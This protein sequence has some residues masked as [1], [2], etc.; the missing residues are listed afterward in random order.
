MTLW[1]VGAKLAD[2]TNTLLIGGAA[3]I[4]LFLLTRQGGGGGNGAPLPTHDPWF[5]PPGGGGGGGGITSLDFTGLADKFKTWA[6]NTGT[7]DTVKRWT[8]SRRTELGI[9]GDLFNLD[10]GG[11]GGAGKPAASIADVLSALNTAT[12]V[13]EVTARF[14]K[15]PGAMLNMGL[16]KQVLG[17]TVEDRLNQ[18]SKTVM[19]KGLADTLYRV[20][21]SKHTKSLTVPKAWSRYINKPA[22]SPMGGFGPQSYKVSRGMGANALR[23]VSKGAMLGVPGLGT[24]V[25]LGR[26]ALKAVS[27]T[28]MLPRVGPLFWLAEVPATLYE[29]KTGKD[30]PVLG[31]GGTSL[32][33]AAASHGKDIWRVLRATPPLAYSAFMR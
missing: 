4:G 18:V 8:D 1:H 30:I 11:G 26:G 12:D 6:L 21:P 25:G 31:L 29:W 3:L 14:A 5:P 7:L 24:G 20:N 32:P 27:G 23:F 9:A 33:R 17:Q 22:P 28:K 15:H 19:A 2:N 10:F 13:A 16:Q